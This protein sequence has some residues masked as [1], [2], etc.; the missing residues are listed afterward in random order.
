MYG[1]LNL[2]DISIRRYFGWVAV[3]FGLLFALIDD[4]PNGILGS[5]LHLM[6]WQLQTLVPMA[7]LYF[8]QS[9][10]AQVKMIIT[11]N[12]WIQLIF[13]GVIATIIFVPLAI[14]IEIAFGEKIES[15]VWLEIIHEYTST[16][17]PIIV[18]WLAINAPWVFGFRLVREP[19]S[20]E[21]SGP[22]AKTPAFYS[23]IPPDMRGDL[24]YLE[25]E[26]HYLAVITTEGRSLILYNLKDAVSELPEGL[27]VQTHRSYWVALPYV[28]QLKRIKR[29]GNLIMS[30]GDHV[31]VSR[32]K[33]DLVKDAYSVY[34]NGQKFAKQT[35]VAV[36][37]GV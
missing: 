12:P 18:S 17:P 28:H 9:L 1:Q 11:F 6:Q 35:S 30:N 19:Q 26:L 10:L 23:L 4:F 37:T 22:S 36:R 16:A 2:G 27:G 29:Q 25:A 3:I 31:P 14:G 32:S 20:E 34:N 5:L 13:G 15:P 24:I 8:V 7:L 21:V 33:F